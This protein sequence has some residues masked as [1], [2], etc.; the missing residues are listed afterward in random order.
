LKVREY[1]AAGLPSHCTP[2]PEAIQLDTQVMVTDQASAIVSWLRQTL[3]ND[4]FQ[5]RLQRRESVSGDAWSERSNWVRSAVQ[6]LVDQ[7]TG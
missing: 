1:L 3:V 6:A 7:R 5:Q 4:T 2:I